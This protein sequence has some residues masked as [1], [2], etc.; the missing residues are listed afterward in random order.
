MGNKKIKKH[1]HELTNEEFLKL[2][3][4]ARGV[5]IDNYSIDNV[6][7]WS[8]C[9]IMVTLGYMKI[10]FGIVECENDVRLGNG[11]SFIMKEYLSKDNISVSEKGI[12][13]N[14]E[15]FIDEKMVLVKNQNIL[16]SQLEV[17]GYM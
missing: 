2:F 6:Q 17:M 10:S 8:S 1:L 5:Y 11:F 12:E 13:S 3:Q 14:K 7:R 9:D 15:D 16:F 4:I